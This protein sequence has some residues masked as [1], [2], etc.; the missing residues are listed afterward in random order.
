MGWVR[1]PVLYDP[2]TQIEGDG[3][4]LEEVPVNIDANLDN[5]DW[6]KR[7]WDLPFQTEAQLQI[8]L[9]AKGMTLEQ[10]SQLPVYQARPW[11]DRTVTA[12]E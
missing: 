8:W 1:K 7:T 4:D 6:P 9:D 11:R 5:A 3:W 2:V 10:F 12:W